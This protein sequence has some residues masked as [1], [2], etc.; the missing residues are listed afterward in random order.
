MF[1]LTQQVQDLD[2]TLILLLEFNQ[3]LAKTT[4]RDRYIGKSLAFK[5]VDHINLTRQTDAGQP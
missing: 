3:L 1:G 4:N 5:E 2:L